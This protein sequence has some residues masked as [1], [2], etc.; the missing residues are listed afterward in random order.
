MLG[1]CNGLIFFMLLDFLKPKKNCFIF[2]GRD[3]D[4]YYWL[5]GR[6]DD[7][8]NVRYVLINVSYSLSLSSCQ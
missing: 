8:I 4:G 1:G 7:V 5:T 6:V 3:E 2:V